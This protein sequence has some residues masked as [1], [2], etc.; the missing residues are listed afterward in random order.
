MISELTETDLEIVT[1]GDASND[2]NPKDV[3]HEMGKECAI[4]GTAG[5]IIGGAIGALVGREIDRS[6]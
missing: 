4:K 3:I 2:P 6:C 5:A 1:G